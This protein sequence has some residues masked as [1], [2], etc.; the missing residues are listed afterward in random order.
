MLPAELSPAEMAEGQ[1]ALLPRPD[2]GE[3][4]K[5]SREHASNIC[6]CPIQLSVISFRDYPRFL[7][8]PLI[9][10]GSNYRSPI[11]R[12]SDRSMWTDIADASLAGS[13]QSWSI[14]AT[15]AIATIAVM[16]AHA[17]TICDVGDFN[18]KITRS[19]DLFGLDDKSFQRTCFYPSFIRSTWRTY[20]AIK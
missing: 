14:A 9:H 17:E 11:D 10:R 13:R 18:A 19:R 8:I 7:L 3:G 15:F 4:E 1:E 12:S 6:P 20:S 5:S 2:P 16:C